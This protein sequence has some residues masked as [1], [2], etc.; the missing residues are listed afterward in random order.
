MA[1]ITRIRVPL[2]GRS[3]T[4]EIG[5]DSLDSA[6]E[7]VRR[8]GDF[9]HG[10]IVT[11]ENV[12]PLYAERL[13][14]SL[15]GVGLAIDLF[16]IPAGEE[17]KSLDM[18]RVLWEGLLSSG[19]D[20][21][22]LVIALGGGVVG[23]LAGFV[24]ATYA[25]GIPYFQVP[26][27]LLAM[28]D[29]SVGGKTG[30]DL[31]GGKNMVGAFHQPIG[32]LIDPTT[33]TTL[34]KREYRAGFGEV[35]K[36]AVS[37]DAG[38]FEFLEQKS[39]E[40]D[41]RQ[42]D[43]L[44]QII[45]RCCRIKAGIVRADERETTGLRALLNYGHTF[46]HAYETAGEFTLFRHGEAVALGMLDALRLA[47]RLGKKGRSE[48]LAVDT[49][50]LRRQEKLFRAISLPT[51]LDAFD[52]P[53]KGKLAANWEHEALFALMLH[54]KKTLHQT[55]RFVLPT[56]LGRCNLFADI[57]ANAVRQTLKERLGK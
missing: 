32:V 48:F 55:P 36:Y 33:L 29:S 19:A 24:A 41:R 54:D 35:V 22:T 56:G 7:R 6:G 37:L 8:L 5:G 28:V 44:T 2:R 12:E 23:D 47:R 45:A 13:A 40:I 50:L 15:S 42:E 52:L 57:P 26:T 43:V 31:A 21:S 46:A 11:D 27:T 51:A 39:A 30:I 20:R 4:I 17:S 49:P 3:Y 9:S 25:R 10:V 18:A 38:L 53:I 14:R 1:K 34:P 16:V